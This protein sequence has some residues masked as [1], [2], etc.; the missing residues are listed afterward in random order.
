MKGKMLKKLIVKLALWW[1]DVKFDRNL[2]ASR[3]RAEKI[4]KA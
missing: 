1:E 2:Q 4:S 3:L